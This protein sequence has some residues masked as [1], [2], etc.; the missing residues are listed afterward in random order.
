MTCLGNALGN[1]STVR[2]LNLCFN[3][4]T[5]SG[6]R[7]FAAAVLQNPDSA[8][9]TLDLGSNS[10]DYDSLVS[11]A[12]S[13]MHNSKLKEL[14]LDEEEDMIEITNWDA[15]SHVL[16][17]ESSGIMGTFR[18]NHTLQRVFNPDNAIDSCAESLLPSIL[19]TLLQLNREHTKVEA[20]RRKILKVHF[21][22]DFNMEPFIDMNMKVVPHAIAWMAKDEYGSSL[23]YQFVRYTTFFVGIGG[24]AQSEDEHSSKRQKTE[25]K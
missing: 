13:L 17:N 2:W 23:L 19:S 21:S 11:F 25:K 4:A 10:I 22:G 7:A 3:D 15:L 1:N 18:S 9:E 16:C 14:F 8:L 6:W 12:N 24:I 5:A 20:A